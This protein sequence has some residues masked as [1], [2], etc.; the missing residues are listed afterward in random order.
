M[1]NKP[2]PATVM[3]APM[4]ADLVG[5]A[6]CARR[7]MTAVSSRAKPAVAVS[8]SSANTGMFVTVPSSRCGLNSHSP[9]TPAI[10][11]T[12]EAA[13]ARPVSWT[14]DTMMNSLQ[15]RRPSPDL[16]R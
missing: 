4:R 9:C 2:A 6:V 3:S 12:P 11:S 13:A 14:L 8:R 15:V 7:P 10:I 16:R 5:Q 1:T